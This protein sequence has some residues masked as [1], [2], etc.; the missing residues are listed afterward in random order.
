MMKKRLS[1]LGICLLLA[2][3]SFPDTI[4]SEEAR[5]ASIAAD[6]DKEKLDEE[7]NIAQANTQI[8]D[9]AS[10]DG[11]IIYYASKNETFTVLS[12]T[13]E[14]YEIENSETTGFIHEQ[15]LKH[16]PDNEL[17]KF[18]NKTIVLDA[19][20]GGRD[21]GAIGESGSYEK[22]F[23]YHTT[24]ELEQ[25]LKLLGAN[26]ILTRE[27]DDFI[28]LGGRTSLANVL[29]TDAFIS[30]HYNSTPELPQVTGIGTYYYHEQDK[31][32]AR[33]IQSSVIQTTDADDR[34]AASENLHVTRQTF[35]PAILIELGFLSNQE[36]ESL[37]KRN[38]YQKKI[39]A[40]IIQGLQ[41]YF[42]K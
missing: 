31:E 2:G 41:H 14:W 18:K 28:A 38:P 25:E 40:G 39:V 9:A 7:I 24:M 6:A 29:D 8:R 27:V 22:D 19:G 30:I 12:V 37:L 10:T 3:L 4:K 13:D 34:G 32:L 36:E 33:D 35:K 5:N 11:E 20:H 17:S 26:V 15:L 23:T 21:V 42:N 16:T 1:F